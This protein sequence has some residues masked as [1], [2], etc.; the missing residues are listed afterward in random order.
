M[1]AFSSRYVIPEILCSIVQIG[2]IPSRK[3]LPFPRLSI[4]Q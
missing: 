4:L 1:P 2:S 3:R